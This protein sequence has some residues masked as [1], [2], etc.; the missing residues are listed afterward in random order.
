MIRFARGLSILA[1]AL[2]ASGQVVLS[3]PGWLIPYPVPG[4]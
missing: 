1:V 4:R 3:L 2:T